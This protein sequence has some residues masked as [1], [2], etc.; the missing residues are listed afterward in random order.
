MQNSKMREEE[1]AMTYEDKQTPLDGARNER[2]E[3]WMTRRHKPAK[4][5]L[6]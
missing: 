5:Y 6:P 4:S 3:K 2:R 1:D